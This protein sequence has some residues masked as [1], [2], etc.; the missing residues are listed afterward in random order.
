MSKTGCAPSKSAVVYSEDTVFCDWDTC[1]TFVPSPP[2]FVAA[3]EDPQR[4]DESSS[5]DQTF[6]SDER[7][8]QLRVD[9]VL[10]E[11]WLLGHLGPCGSRCLSGSSQHQFDSLTR[12]LGVWIANRHHTSLL[13]KQL[14]CV[15]FDI[16]AMVCM[17]G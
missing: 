12:S 13:Q 4:C 2:S 7:R 6:G 16:S 14:I 3:L 8:L 1:F 17:D 9:Y 15:Y 11:L 5:G 10:G